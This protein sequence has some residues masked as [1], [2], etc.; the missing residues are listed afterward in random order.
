MGISKKVLFVEGGDDE[1]VVEK[2][3]Q[4]RKIEFKDF[5]INNQK[6]LNKL[7]KA[8]PIQLS[9]A[10]LT[11]VGVIVDADE[12]ISSRWQELFVLLQETGYSPNPKPNPKGTILEADGLPKV[13]IWIMPNNQD[14]GTLESFIK[15]LAE[16]DSLL[17]EAEST[18][19]D[20]LDTSK[21]RFSPSNKRKATIHTWL[22]WQ[23]RPELSLG[24]AVTY[25]YEEKYLLDD[26]KS[27]D[28]VN[29]LKNLFN[30]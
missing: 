27:N 15:F 25:K 8:L 29:W 24:M 17:P 19:Q 28:F 26:K 30:D 5:E 4:R 20:L 12:N 7:I 18:V 23:K 3:L 1:A 10:S 9:T 13:G 2:L 21:A 16:G 11:T 6:G 22:A 14:T